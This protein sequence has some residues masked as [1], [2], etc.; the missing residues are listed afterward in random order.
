M[1]PWVVALVAL[2]GCSVVASSKVV[3]RNS[4]QMNGDCDCSTQIEN[5]G[6]PMLVAKRYTPGTTNG[7]SMSFGLRLA[8]PQRI[9]IDQS[10][11]RFELTRH[12]GVV[13]G[14][15]PPLGVCC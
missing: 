6:A 1:I 7:S 11:E 3:L 5:E 2:F 9:G 14:R 15:A 12:G 4:A 8:A 13:Q 10:G